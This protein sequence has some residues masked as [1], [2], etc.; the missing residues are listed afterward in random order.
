MDIRPATKA[1][2]LY[3]ARQSHEISMITEY[4]GCLQAKLDTLENNFISTWN[5]FLSEWNTPEFKADLERVLQEL[6]FGEKETPFLANRKALMD[7][8]FAHLDAA[9][10]PDF[11]EFGFRLNTETYV[12]MLKCVPQ[13]GDFNVWIYCYTRK[14]FEHHLKEAEKGI[15]FTDASY[16]TLFKI[17]DGGMVE[18]TYSD[19]EKLRKVCRYI[20]EYHME[21]GD[22]PN[23]YHIH[24]FGEIMA[25]CEAEVKP[26][27]E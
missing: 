11:N 1:E 7:F 4:I 27:T 17:P 13:K 3:L 9:L 24:H 8:C 18:I 10:D 15:T 16:Q 25:R 22:R 6:R 21:I 26:F 2:Q 14:W 23:L 12:Y 19:G 20:D 5:T